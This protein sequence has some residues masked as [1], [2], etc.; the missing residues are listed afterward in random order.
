[1]GPLLLRWYCYRAPVTVDESSSS[2]SS[3]SSAS[4]TT[5][6]LS[7]VTCLFYFDEPVTAVDASALTVYYSTV[8]SKGRINSFDDSYPLSPSASNYTAVSYANYNRLVTLQLPNYCAAAV[9][10]AASGCTG[11]LRGADLYSFLAQE[12]NTVGRRFFIAVKSAAALDMAQ[13]PNE[14]NTIRPRFAQQESAPGALTP[15]RCKC[16]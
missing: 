8:N 14:A 1:M 9:D 7:A 11:S 10:G 2:S 4:S 12:T 13:T 5:S 6:A 15:I 16:C 3:S